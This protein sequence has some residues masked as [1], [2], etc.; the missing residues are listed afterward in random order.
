LLT[1]DSIILGTFAG[2]FN[3]ILSGE[4]I[5]RERSIKFL[6]TRYKSFGSSTITKEVEDYVIAEIK[7][8]L[9]VNLI[10]IALCSIMLMMNSI[11][12]DVT[13]DE[14]KLL[15]DVLSET[16]LGKTLSGHQE[17]IDLVVDQA[18]L[19]QPFSGSDPENVYRLI[20]CTQHAL[21]F[22]SV[23]NIFS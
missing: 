17:M 18:E 21:P 20:T 15:M 22:F 11:I 23:S 3:Q 19:D 5:V 7:K 14:F 4:E 13:A 16:R 2:V 10:L 9:Q 8:V 6:S 1:S 12:K